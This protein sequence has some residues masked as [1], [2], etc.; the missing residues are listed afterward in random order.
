MN[1]IIHL[2][3]FNPE[4]QAFHDRQCRGKIRSESKTQTADPRNKTQAEDCRLFL[5]TVIKTD[6]SVI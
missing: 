2:N 6:L 4:Y 3:E 5:L 1:N